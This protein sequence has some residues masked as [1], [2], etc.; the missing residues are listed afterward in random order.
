[1]NNFF[2][3]KKKEK[4]FTTLVGQKKNYTKYIKIYEKVLSEISANLSF[5]LK[6]NRPPIFWRAVKG[7]Y[8]QELLGKL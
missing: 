8:L 4:Y 6:I 3:N 1:M 7:P 5:E 2:Y